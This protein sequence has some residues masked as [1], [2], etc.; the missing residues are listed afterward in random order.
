VSELWRKQRQALRV[1][2]IFSLYFTQ[3]LLVVTKKTTT[4]FFFLAM[5]AA[6][7]HAATP[8]PRKRAKLCGE[9]ASASASVPVPT[10]TR[11]LIASVLHMVAYMRRHCA[12]LEPDCGLFGPKYRGLD[13]RSGGV[14]TVVADVIADF[15][16]RPLRGAYMKHVNAYRNGRVSSMT[17]DANADEVVMFVAT[18]DGDEC[19]AEGVSLDRVPVRADKYGGIFYAMMPVIKSAAQ[20]WHARSLSLARRFKRDDDTAVLFADTLQGCVFLKFCI[21][22]VGWD[23]R[24]F[25]EPTGVC[26]TPQFIAVVERG[27]NRVTLIN[28]KSLKTLRSTKK[29][30]PGH[31]VYTAAWTAVCSFGSTGSGDGELCGPEGACITRE[32]HIA[33]ADAGNNRV[34][35]FRADGTF[36]RHVGVG[37]LTAPRRVACMEATGELAVVDLHGVHVFDGN[38]RCG[39]L[40]ARSDGAITDVAAHH[41]T[42]YVQRGNKCYVF[43]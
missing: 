34:C 36:V 20:I 16:R 40:P 10:G 5:A 31:R 23:L 18:D 3:F 1:F 22:R 30:T 42:L 32:G 24:G 11:L 4:A 6:M 9:V 21:G 39:V 43:V 13:R 17:Y 35:V 7:S 15:L 29:L 41:G 28:W 8:T 19:L 12:L 2:V 27:A 37:V 14:A 38:A 26:S 33:V 25:H